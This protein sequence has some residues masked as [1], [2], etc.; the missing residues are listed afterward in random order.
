MRP[1][2]KKNKAWQ[3][4][5]LNNYC[6]LSTPDFW[7]ITSATVQYHDKLFRELAHILAI[8]TNANQHFYLGRMTLFS[9]QSTVPWNTLSNTRHIVHAPPKSHLLVKPKLLYSSQTIKA[10]KINHGVNDWT[11]ANSGLFHSSTPTQVHSPTRQVHWSHLHETVQ[12]NKSRLKLIHSM[13]KHL[14]LCGNPGYALKHLLKQRSFIGSTICKGTKFVRSQKIYVLLAHEQVDDLQTVLSCSVCLLYFWLSGTRK[15][16]FLGSWISDSSVVI[17]NTVCGV[18][19]QYEVEVKL[20]PVRLNECEI[21]N[22]FFWWRGW[23]L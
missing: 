12:P 14:S 20:K 3:L 19:I 10:A 21:I 17:C 13:S 6:S 22:A 2:G 8:I 4:E 23:E 15:M 18:V 1:P 5:Q 16:F 7:E 11:W 9:C